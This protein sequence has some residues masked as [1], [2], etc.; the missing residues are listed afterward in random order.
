MSFALSVMVILALRNVKACVLKYAKN[1]TKLA[2]RNV[3][4]MLVMAI[5]IFALRLT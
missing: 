2:P 1:G 5:L 3:S 4:S